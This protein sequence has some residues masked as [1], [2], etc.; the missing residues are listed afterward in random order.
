MI[1]ENTC[2]IQ[3][4][5]LWFVPH[6]R[7]TLLKKYTK[8]NILIHPF[9]EKELNKS[10]IDTRKE[11]NFVIPTYDDMIKDMIFQAKNDKSIYSHYDLK[12]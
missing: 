12:K 2:L 5:I 8:K 9:D 7:L 3:K 11:L 4:R 6:T 10:F 1:M